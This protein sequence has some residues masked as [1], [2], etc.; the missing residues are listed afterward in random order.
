ME[1]KTDSPIMVYNIR[2]TQRADRS[3]LEE[4]KTVI[5]KYDAALSEIGKISAYYIGVKL[6]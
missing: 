5:K 6:R 1:G 4:M 3:T 2:H